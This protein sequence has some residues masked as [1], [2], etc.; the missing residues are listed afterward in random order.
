M[1]SYMI[2]YSKPNKT[3]RHFKEKWLSKYYCEIMIFSYYKDFSI[4][5]TKIFDTAIL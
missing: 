4:R 1:I 3:N 2:K 5:Y